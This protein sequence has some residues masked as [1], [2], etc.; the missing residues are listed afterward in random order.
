[1]TVQFHDGD[2]KGEI[3][4]R[5]RPS[6]RHTSLYLNIV[7]IKEPIPSKATFFYVPRL[8][9]DLKEEILN[10]IAQ[11]SVLDCRAFSIT[12]KGMYKRLEPF[13]I[14]NRNPLFNI[15]YAQRMTV[16]VVYPKKR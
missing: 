11:L 7:L 4:M 6:D 8:P 5:L 10:R 14:K 1:M 2:S 13:L 16:R 3:I 9:N 12:C 15:K